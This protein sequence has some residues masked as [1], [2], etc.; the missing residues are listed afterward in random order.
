MTDII[1]INPKKDTEFKVG[2]NGIA[3]PMAFPTQTTRKC[4]A[5]QFPNLTE[6]QV[7][8]YATRLAETYWNFNHGRTADPPSSRWRVFILWVQHEHGLTGDDCIINSF[9]LWNMKNFKKYYKKYIRILFRIPKRTGDLAVFQI[10]AGTEKVSRRIIFEA[11]RDGDRFRPVQ[12]N[13]LQ[14]PG[15]ANLVT[16][17]TPISQPIWGTAAAAMTTAA[18]AGDKPVTDNNAND[19]EDAP[20]PFNPGIDDGDA[21]DD[22]ILDGPFTYPTDMDDDDGGDDGPGTWTTEGSDNK[23]GR[24]PPNTQSGFGGVDVS[25]AVFDPSAV[26][27]NLFKF[28]IDDG[29]AWTDVGSGPNGDSTYTVPGYMT[30]S[31]ASTSTSMTIVGET[32]TKFIQELSQTLKVGANFAGFGGEFSRTYDDSTK[33]ETWK[34]YMATYHQTL[35]YRLGF[36]DIDHARNY[37]TDTA[38][39]AFT[40]WPAEKIVHTFGTHYMTSATFGGIRITSS[41]L[42]VRD[43]IKDTKLKTAIELKAS[44]SDPEMDLDATVKDSS[45]DNTVQQIMN[46][47]ELVHTRTIGGVANDSNVQA[48]RNSL[49]ANPVVVDYDIRPIWELIDDPNLAQEVKNQVNTLLTT[50]QPYDPC[51][52]LAMYVPIKKYADDRDSHAKCDLTVAVPDVPEGWLQLCQYAQCGTWNDSFNGANNKGIAV[53][54]NPNRTVDRDGNGKADGNQPPAVMGATGLDVIWQLWRSDRNF[55]V[56][57]LKGPSA[58]YAAVGDI[59]ENQCDPNAVQRK[60]YAVFHNRLLKQCKLKTNDPKDGL[61]FIWN[62]QRSGAGGNV[63][64]VAPPLGLCQVTDEA[65]NVKDMPIFVNDPAT[66]MGYPFY[67]TAVGDYDDT[68][69]ITASMLDWSKVKWL[70]ADWLGAP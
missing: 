68:F 18:V 24:L 21:D 65:G 57:H 59:F 5:L 22:G 3:F 64:L 20:V 32:K 28:P 37:L 7:N 51:D 10:C 53:R 47:M 70:E 45:K 8:L 43:N 17:S 11:V 52:I 69:E 44:Y 33:V 48:W 49:Y 50:T 54:I 36:K 6:R 35:I 66:G 38:R 46:K 62:D 63:V 12:L 30:F 39:E 41:S 23:K 55:A 40:S 1:V 25:C 26:R 29:T 67:G 14:A 15:D 16:I 61:K 58:D 60:R 9:G 4:I 56:Y 31:W 19:D 34:K 27:T 42:D 13:P 2:D